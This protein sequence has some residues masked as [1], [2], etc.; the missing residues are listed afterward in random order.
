MKFAA[1]MAAQQ[2]NKKDQLSFLRTN[3][4]S[5]DD[6]PVACV[7][8]GV[9]IVSFI[10]DLFVSVLLLND[11]YNILIYYLVS[12]NPPSIYYHRHR[13]RRVIIIYM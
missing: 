12:A 10:V 1:F 8:E 9:S 6:A 11:L 13:L 2:A 7:N 3:I 4:G 5:G